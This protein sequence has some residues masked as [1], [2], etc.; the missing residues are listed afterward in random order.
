MYLF[1]CS[2]VSFKIG[3]IS[4]SNRSGKHHSVGYSLVKLSLGCWF[5]FMVVSDPNCHVMFVLLGNWSYSQMVNV[6]VQRW[7]CTIWARSG[8]SNRRTAAKNRMFLISE[9]EWKSEILYRSQGRVFLTLQGLNKN[10]FK[11]REIMR[12]EN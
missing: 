3:S 1:H 12:I 8:F 10:R 6:P 11:C 7:W 2:A 9:S 4:K 5:K